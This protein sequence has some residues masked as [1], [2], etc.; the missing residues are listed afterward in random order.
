MG[1]S[2]YACIGI[3]VVSLTDKRFALER[4]TVLSEAIQA[5]RCAGVFREGGVGGWVGKLGS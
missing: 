1:A 5:V 4:E 2:C 3:F